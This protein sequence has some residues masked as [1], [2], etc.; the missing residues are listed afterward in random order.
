MDGLQ[1]TDHQRVLS[2]LR[3]LADEPRPQGCEKLYDDIYRLRVGDI[4][5]IY[6]IDEGNKRIEVGGVRRRSERTYKCIED[7]FR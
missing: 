3:G 4:R 1:E 2:K 5:I 7:L 6:L